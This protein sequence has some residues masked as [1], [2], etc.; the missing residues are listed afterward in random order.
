MGANSRG[1]VKV[2][3]WCM[4]MEVCIIKVVYIGRISSPDQERKTRNGGYTECKTG[5][6]ADDQR[7]RAGRYEGQ[8][9]SQ[10]GS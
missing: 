10:K 1:I 3:W 4:N 9:S 7:R 2:V 6:K 8:N 5:R